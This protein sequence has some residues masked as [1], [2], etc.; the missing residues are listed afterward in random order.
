[1]I[2]TLQMRTRKLWKLKGL[3]KSHTVN[4]DRICIRVSVLSPGSVLP[5]LHC[6][7][8][9]QS[10]LFSSHSWEAITSLV[11]K[12]S[13]WICWIL[14]LLDACII[15]SVCYLAAH[16]LMVSL[17]SNVFFFPLQEKPCLAW[18]RK[19]IYTPKLPAFSS[20]TFRYKAAELCTLPPYSS[21]FLSPIFCH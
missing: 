6:S 18:Q 13:Q 7:P 10:H 1:M 4:E 20:W 17:V 5:P 9:T 12:F 16:H 21:L 15:L 8:F 19:T 11:A 2:L 14:N 3:A